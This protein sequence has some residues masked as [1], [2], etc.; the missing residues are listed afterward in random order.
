M[1]DISSRFFGIIALIGAWIVFK[2]N[3]KNN[4]LTNQ[5]KTPLRDPNE[6]AVT[7]VIRTGGLS[8]EEKQKLEL[9]SIQFQITDFVQNGQQSDIYGYY[10]KSD[11]KEIEGLLG[12]CVKISGVIP[13]EWRNKD[14]GG[15]DNI[16]YTYSRVVL[17]PNKVERVDFLNCSPYSYRLPVDIT[18][19]Q[20]KLS[21]RGVVS[22]GVRPA[23]DISYDYQL[24]PSEPFFDELDSQ[25]RPSSVRFIDIIPGINSAWIELENNIGKEV[26]VEG[27]MVW[28]Y[29]ESRY[30]EIISVKSINNS[31]EEAEV[32]SLITKFEK[33]I[34]DRNV[35]ALMPLFTSAKTAE[36]TT[37]YRNLM[38]LDPDIGAPRLFI[39]VT[40]NF[41]VT[42]WKIARREYPDNKELITKENDKYLVTVEETRKSWCNADPCA[43]AYSFENTGPYI[44]EIINVNSQW[45]VDKYYFMNQRNV[46]GGPK[47]EALMF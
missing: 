27:Y 44:F 42:N 5:R 38:G 16:P 25:G 7:G 39:N 41:I 10:L 31:S 3:V 8:E 18:D 37:S 15:M 19:N 23:P 29:S 14:I 36:E 43:G 32:K 35:K 20:Q 2:P 21:I 1:D 28:G 33:Y 26:T 47:Y 22:Y 46:N 45:M 12:K 9:S 17:V 13:N 6:V 24:K 4:T 40:S 34:Q 30:L 11:N